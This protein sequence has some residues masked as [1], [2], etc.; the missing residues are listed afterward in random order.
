M[1]WCKSYLSNRKQYLEYKNNFNEQKCTNLLQTKCG[2][3]QGSILGPLLFLV[4]INDLSLVSKFLSPIMFVDDTNLFYSHNN[5]KILFKNTNDKLEKSSKRFK[6]NKLSLNEG[7]TKFTLFHKPRHKDNLPL[8]LPN[9]KI[10]NNEIKRSSSIKFLG[11]LVDENLTWIDHITLVENKL[12]KNLGLLHKAK[13]YDKIVYD[14]TKK[15]F[16]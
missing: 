5:I 2:V 4:Y 6:A 12:S 10:N 15:T 14:K 7:N 3:P 9:L 1:L 16:I 11:V 13:N 8:Q